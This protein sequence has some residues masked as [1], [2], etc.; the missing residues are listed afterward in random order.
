MLKPKLKPKGPLT[1]PAA[2]TLAPS[3]EAPAATAPAPVAAPAERPTLKPTLKPAGSDTARLKPISLGTPKEAAPTEETAKKSTSRVDLDDARSGTAEVGANAAGPKTIRIKPAQLS[4]TPPAA[5]A[6]AAANDP[7]RQTSRISLESAL[8]GTDSPA[9]S[10]GPKT[11]R[12]KRPSNI[13]AVK[14]GSGTLSK[15]TQLKTDAAG[16]PSPT[17]TQ[18]RTIKVKRPTAARRAPQVKAGG[19]PGAAAGA[20]SP[21]PSAPVHVAPTPPTDGAHWTFIT[22]SILA[23]LLTAG[24]I[25][26]LAAQAVGPNH[27]LTQLSSY[28]Q[29]PDLPMAGKRTRQ[30]QY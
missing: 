27:S 26:V 24:T 1:P 19:R 8:A 11:I 15:T 2:A 13:P 20:G 18:K 4:P 21:T 12:L 16:V 3:A 5:A 9:A 25:Y 22:F 6:A 30:V 17:P 7:K 28:K 23:M 29:G 14:A 10:S